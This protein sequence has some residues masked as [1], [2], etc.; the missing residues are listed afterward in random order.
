[1]VRWLG[2]EAELDAARVRYRGF[3]ITVLNLPDPVS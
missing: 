2:R 3:N 1:M